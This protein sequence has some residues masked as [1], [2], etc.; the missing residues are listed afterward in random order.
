[1][2]MLSPDW[3]KKM[4]MQSARDLAIMHCAKKHPQM[5]IDRETKAW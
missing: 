3:S 2:C 5:K 1:M 4:Q